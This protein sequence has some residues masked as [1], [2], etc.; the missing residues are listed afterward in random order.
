M[1]DQTIQHGQS[2]CLAA[3]SHWA[4]LTAPENLAAFTFGPSSCCC[5]QIPCQEVAESTVQ[6]YYHQAPGTVMNQFTWLTRVT[7]PKY[8]ILSWPGS[9]WTDRPLLILPVALEFSFFSI[10]TWIFCVPPMYF[11]FEET[12]PHFS[13]VHVSEA[14]GGSGNCTNGD[15][16][17]L[18][19]GF[20]ARPWIRHFT[21]WFLVFSKM[22]GVELNDL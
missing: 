17:G 12:H 11:S 7:L 2:S 14:V 13:H 8:L 10:S 5:W 16:A 15:P 20:R 18:G 21:S 4:T 3:I 19:S 9:Q 1:W 22:R 6:L